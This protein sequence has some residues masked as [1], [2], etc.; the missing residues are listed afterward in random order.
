MT[1]E[2]DEECRRRTIDSNDCHKFDVAATAVSVY[3]LEIASSR[4]HV[5]GFGQQPVLLPVWTR[6][7]SLVG[8]FR[9]LFSRSDLI[10]QALNGKL[11]K[12]YRVGDEASCYSRGVQAD[13]DD[14]MAEAHTL[15]LYRNLFFFMS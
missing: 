12:R 1:Y 11:K 3:K 10:F 8:L 5:D 7:R 2:V 13:F 4:V 14:N 9:V 6:K 15:S